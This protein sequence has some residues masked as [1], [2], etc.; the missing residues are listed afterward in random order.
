M[1]SFRSAA[2]AGSRGRARGASRSPA[3][4]AP[5]GSA[6]DRAELEQVRVF[7]GHLRVLEREIAHA[8]AEETGCCGVSL[9]QC[10]LL[11]EVE[12]RGRT[13]I[14]ELTGA[15]ELDKS[16][17]SRTVEAMCQ[18]G[19]LS[20]VIDPQN[21][22]HQF[23]SLTGKGSRTADAINS[24][25]DGSYQRLLRW[26]PRDKVS[27]VMESVALVAEAMRRARKEEQ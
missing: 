11:L 1:Q 14:T 26:I 2:K 23:I 12:S 6:P 3:C 5:G 22:R 16:T 21:R 8:M 25:C 17:L 13:G 20:R 10:H 9:A 7:R 15:L 19:L 27:L 24:L 18:K 4:G